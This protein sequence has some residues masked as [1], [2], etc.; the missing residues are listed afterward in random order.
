MTGVQTELATSSLVCFKK[1]HILD[2]LLVT[3][4][5]S[6]L[7]RKVKSCLF[8]EPKIV[9]GPAS[10]LVSWRELEVSQYLRDE[11]MHLT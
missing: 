9:M 8:V 3:L 5:H 11:F 1:N 7:N 4:S 2:T 10:I 6:S